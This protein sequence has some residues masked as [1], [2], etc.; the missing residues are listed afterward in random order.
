M[1]GN[2]SGAWGRWGD[3]DVTPAASS[4][5]YLTQLAT[6]A[7]PIIGAVSGGDPI[8]KAAVATADY[9]AG[10]VRGA[11]VGTLAV[12][13]AKMDAANYNA[14]Q[15]MISQDSTREWATLGK[16]GVITGIGVGVAVIV[17]LVVS[18]FKK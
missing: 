14:Q 2:R 9:K 1:I 4:T 15:A 11:S 6:I 18:A 17:L 12:L 8:T 10:L 3:G 7:A 16:T 13:K 5:D